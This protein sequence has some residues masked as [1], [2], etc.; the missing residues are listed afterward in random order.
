[1][2]SWVVTTG[3]Y[4]MKS[5]FRTEHRRYDDEGKEKEK[6]AFVRDA[7]F[8]YVTTLVHTLY[9]PFKFASP[10]RFLLRNLSL[11]C[12]HASYKR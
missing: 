12:P 4:T 11:H 5:M 1:M 9:T 7:R 2:V 8:L 6:L 10:L 3:K